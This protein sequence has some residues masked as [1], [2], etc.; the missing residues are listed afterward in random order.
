MLHRRQLTLF[1]PP[2]QGAIVEP[3]RQRLD[4]R[5]HAIVPAHVTLCRD[6]ELAPWEVLHQRL[7]N[8]E[9]FAVML[10]FGEPQV[11][12]DGCVLLRPVR[13][14]EQ[15]QQLRQAILGPSAK[16][17]GAHIT[18]LH[19]RNA[20]GVLYDVAEIAS[21]LAGLTVTFRTIALIEQSG[22]EPWSVQQEYGATI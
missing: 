19:P 2:A 3:I 4:P 18:L 22:S 21:V 7:A 11:L 8:L 13:G 14:E 5:Q 1:L 15:Y 17:H 16:V 6:D 10:Q 12:S 9:A 20:A